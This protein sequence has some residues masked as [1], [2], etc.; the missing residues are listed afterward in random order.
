[1][2][3]KYKELYRK[4]KNKFVIIGL[5]AL[6]LVT[7]TI[8][9]FFADKSETGEVEEVENTT[10]NTDTFVATE[11]IEEKVYITG[12]VKNPGVYSIKSGDRIENIIEYA[13][14]VTEKAVIENVNLAEIVIDEQH[15]VIPNEETEVQQTTNNVKTGKIN[16]NKAT[17]E[18]LTKL[19]GVGEVTAQSI[20][21]Y[22]D[23]VGK[24]NSIED[25]KNVEGIGD[26]TF[27][28]FKDQID[29]K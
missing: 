17:V 1:M 25:I 20:V 29:V 10:E 18:E 26:K 28:K 12:E 3:D 16:I 2:E 13:G 23:A 8:L 4:N 21:D 7:F 15:I 27:E 11:K 19:N 22:R 9:T 24:F 6:V 5:I 14:G